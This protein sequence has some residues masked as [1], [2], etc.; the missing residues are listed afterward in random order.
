MP[1]IALQSAKH[2]RDSVDDP[3]QVAEHEIVELGRGPVQSESETVTPSDLTHW[4]ERLWT[5]LVDPLQ[6]R[7]L[8]WVPL[9]Q[10][11]PQMDHE[12]QPPH[13]AV[14]EQEP[15]PL[16]CHEYV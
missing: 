2:E 15:H 10:E 14:A 16:V 3:E 13:D 12:L 8:V 9:P 4:T 6:E 5:P 1:I 7:D 11:G